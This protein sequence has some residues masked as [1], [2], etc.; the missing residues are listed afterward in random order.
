MT[1]PANR[2]VETVHPAYAARVDEWQTLRDVLAGSRAVKA[3]ST[4]YLP[5]LNGAP[6]PLLG[7]HVYDSYKSRAKFYA[8]TGKTLDALVGTI[9]HKDIVIDGPARFLEHAKDITMNATPMEDF[10]EEVLKEVIGMG[11]FGILIDMPDGDQPA[12]PRPYWVG[13][14][15]EEITNWR[16]VTFDGDSYLTLVVLKESYETNLNEFEMESHV[17]YRVLSLRTDTRTDEGLAYT[18]QIYKE[19]GETGG[20]KQ[21][22]VVD[23]IIPLKLGKPL[24]FIPFVI[25][26]PT[27]L[28][29]TPEKSPLLEI[30]ETNLHM[31]RRS[32]DLEHGRH[33]TGLPTPVIIGGPQAT[34]GGTPPVM[35]IGST[36]AWWLPPLSDVKYLEFTGQG[37]STL[38]EGMREDKEEIAALGA[39]MFAPEAE[40]GQETATATRV[41]HSARTASLKTYARRTSTGL[42]MCARMH[43]WWTGETESLTDE[44]ILAT[45]NTTF[46]DGK[47]PAE[48]LK[49]WVLTLQAGG[50]SFETFYEQLVKGELTRPG[51]TA[52]EEKAQIDAEAPEP[53]PME[54]LPGENTPPREKT[55]QG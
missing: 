18:Q 12:E 36:V 34:S 45:L 1:L 3:Q 4:R 15:T 37:L 42:S 32:A 30:A 14:R 52:E 17:Q 31:Y 22:I 21:W 10:A 8:A 2:G 38:V 28:A 50:C 35:T 33:F 26:G 20:A 5:A 11:R 47:M 41:R 27:T 16:E 51:V 24:P 40:T 49:A 6:D 53:E 23:T 25:I 13:Y 29:A 48:E 43:A 55:T 39:E 54:Q 9:L 46:L 19:F 7:G 44:K